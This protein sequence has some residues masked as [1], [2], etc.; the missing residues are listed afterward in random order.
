MT[1]LQ[2]SR[3][4]GG[5]KDYALAVGRVIDVQEGVCPGV[6]HHPTKPHFVTDLL[7]GRKEVSQ[8]KVFVPCKLVLP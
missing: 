6:S 8:F 5:T 2:F 3:R 1:A 4:H 7:D